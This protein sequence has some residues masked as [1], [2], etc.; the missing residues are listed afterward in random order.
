M[1][2][3]NRSMVKA[4]DDRYMVIVSSNSYR[5]REKEWIETDALKRETDSWWDGEQFVIPKESSAVLY[6]HKGPVIARVIW[7]D[8]FGPFRVEIAEKRQSRFPVIQAYVDRVW[9][10]VRQEVGEWGASIGFA[11]RQRDI[12]PDPDGDTY[13]DLF[14]RERSVLRRFV[15]ANLLTFSEV[16]Q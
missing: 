11:T 1:P 8:M 5:D 9:K 16:L 3:E 4:L 12:R 6:W 10:R 13:T 15:A 14:T 7:A 2:Y